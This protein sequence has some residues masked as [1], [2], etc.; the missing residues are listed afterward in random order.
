MTRLRWKKSTAGKI[1]A[2]FRDNG[3]RPADD[4]QRRAEAEFEAWSA[5]LPPGKRRGLT[6][7]LSSVTKDFERAVSFS[8]RQRRAETDVLQAAVWGPKRKT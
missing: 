2:D 5:S 7:R 6:K 4:L 8:H 3:F 1:A